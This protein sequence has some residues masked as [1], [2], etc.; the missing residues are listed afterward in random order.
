ML[1]TLS[2]SNSPQNFIQLQVIVWALV[3]QVEA[4][5]RKRR[6]YESVKLVRVQTIVA[7]QMTH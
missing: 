2:S 5:E 7:V 3:L 4:Y 6:G 1:P